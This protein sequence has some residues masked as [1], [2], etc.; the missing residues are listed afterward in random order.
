MGPIKE[1][2][3]AT[4]KFETTWRL[5]GHGQTDDCSEKVREGMEKMKQLGGKSPEPPKETTGRVELTLA[6]GEEKSQAELVPGA[7]GT[8]SVKLRTPCPGWDSRKPPGPNFKLDAQYDPREPIPPPPFEREL[9]IKQLTAKADWANDSEARRKLGKHV[10]L[11][12]VYLHR[13]TGK[14]V[15][16][17]AHDLPPNLSTVKSCV[18][19]DKILIRLPKIEAWLASDLLGDG[20]CEDATKAHEQK[21]MDDAWTEMRSVVEDAIKIVKTTGGPNNAEPN[22]VLS[23]EGKKAVIQESLQASLNNHYESFRRKAEALDKQEAER[24]QLAKKSKSSDPCD[25]YWP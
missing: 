14:D 8:S 18:V 6:D 12:F 24:R 25:G 3:G 11:G 17:D 9:N 13:P 5:K 4:L 20:A 22:S 2:A 1:E 15:E 21:H 23:A 10:D 16:V 7:Q 19:V